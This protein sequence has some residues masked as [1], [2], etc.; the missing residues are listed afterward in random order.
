MLI[1]GLTGSIAMGK[2]RIAGLFA[3][4][5]IP[6][7][8]SD[9]VV[10]RLYRPAGRATQ[11]LA[12]LFPDCLAADGSIDRKEL[13][14]RVMHDRQALRSIERIVHA[15]VREEQRRFLEAACREGRWLAVLDIPLL[16]ETGAERRVDR[17]AVV[18]A[19]PPVQRLRALRRLGM[20][21]QRFR[22]VLDKQMPDAKK[23]ARADFVLYN[24]ADRGRP[25]ASV[26]RIVRAMH[27]LAPDA[28]PGRWR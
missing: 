18:S 28:W 12:R 2:S 27:G 6:V 5:G 14:R 10:H 7:C 1:L 15:M 21:P 24:G 17:V 22:A 9:A 3:R 11:A 26:A 4:F 23:Q 16:L 19:S 13:G 8:D 25:V 20:T